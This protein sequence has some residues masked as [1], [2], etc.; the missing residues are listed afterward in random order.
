MSDRID[1]LKHTYLVK[2][3]NVLAE[4]FELGRDTLTQ[5]EEILRN[6]QRSLTVIF[7]WAKNNQFIRV[8][9]NPTESTYVDRRFEASIRPFATKMGVY[10]EFQG[11]MNV[12]SRDFLEE[13]IYAL[14][15]VA[16]ETNG[17]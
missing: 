1:D 5:T 9:Y 4:E 11:A 12:I 14:R 2:I 6:R 17:E 8:S 3:K 13:L 10:L 16:T 15:E 7:S